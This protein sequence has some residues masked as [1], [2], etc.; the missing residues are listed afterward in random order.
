MVKLSSSQPVNVYQRVYDSNI[1]L[2]RM[3]T[4]KNTN[5][6]IDNGP[7]VVDLPIQNGEIIQFAT[8]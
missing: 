7:F 4:I 2:L 8:C 6:A 1:C 5:I 3:I